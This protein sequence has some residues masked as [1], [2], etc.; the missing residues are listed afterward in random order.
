MPLYERTVTDEASF[1]S[2][3]LADKEKPASGE[4]ITEDEKEEP[5]EK[6][7]EIEKADAEKSE[8]AASIKV[9]SGCF[10]T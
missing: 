8:V 7:E 4:T 5:T 1:M 10:L 3:I 6:T 9:I 2:V